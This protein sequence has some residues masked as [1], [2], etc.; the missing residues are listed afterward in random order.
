MVVTREMIELAFLAPIQHLPLKRRAV[1]ISRWQQTRY[2]PET[3][4]FGGRSGMG[5]AHDLFCSDSPDILA[6]L[7][8]PEPTLGHQVIFS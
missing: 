2:E 5:I 3:A 8:R 7:R 1:L 4:A 6:Y